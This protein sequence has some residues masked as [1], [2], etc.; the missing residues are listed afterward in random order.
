MLTLE[1]YLT[2]LKT[3]GWSG[4]DDWLPHDAKVDYLGTGR[5]R[6]ETLKAAMRK[7]RLVPMHRVDDGIN[8]SRVLFPR[9]K[10]DATRCKDGLEAL[11]Q[12]R[13]EYDEKARVFKT[14]PR[15]DWASHPADAFRYLCMAWREVSSTVATPSKPKLLGV[16]KVNQVTMNDMLK[17]SGVRL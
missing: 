7:P 13:S 4:G 12:Y 5:T 15:H 17:A 8:A 3:R 14:T 6:V 10:F 16:G 2:E 9:I 1:G 11:R